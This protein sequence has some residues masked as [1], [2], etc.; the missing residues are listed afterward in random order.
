MGRVNTIQ[1]YPEA[2]GMPINQFMHQLYEQSL[3]Y[4]NIAYSENGAKMYGTTGKAL[5]DL[6]FSVASLRDSSPE[7]IL[8]K[9]VAAANEDFTLALKWIFYARDVREGLGEV[10]LFSIVMSYLINYHYW[11]VRA[12]I[13]LIPMY[14]RWDDLL[15]LLNTRA[16]SDILTIISKQ[17]HA[18][19]IAMKLKQ[20]ISLMAKWLPSINA[21]SLDSRKKALKILRYLNMTVAQYRHYL[22]RFRRYLDVVEVKMS[23]RRWDEIDYSKVPSKANLLY[24]KAFLRHDMDR[25]SQFIADVLSGKEK[26]NAGV[27]YPHEIVY[28]YISNSFDREEMDTL[29]GIW[30]NLPRVEGG[31]TIVVADGSGSMKRVPSQSSNVRCWDIATALAIYFAEQL[32]GPYN[33]QVI[34]FSEHPRYVDLRPCKN[35]FEKVNKMK[36]YTEVANTNIEAVFDLVLDTAKTNGLTQD[37][38]PKNILILSDME[39]DSC[40]EDSS[41]RYAGSNLFEAISDKYTVAGYK[42]PRVC[43]WNI[44]GS[45]GAIPMIKNDLG[46]AL[47]SGYSINN[48]KLIMSGKLDPYDALLDVLNGERYRNILP[49]PTP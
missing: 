32:N 7:F 8:E 23:E 16:E 4:E 45:S 48:V 12:I 49:D 36:L 42:M 2:G 35:L 13:P 9:F 46:V 24:S 14:G 39:F 18:D 27:V 19:T 26:M 11:K 6:N 37:Q 31:D 43:F 10:R 33:N 34:T 29:L 3:K 25:R 22:D 44:K 40:A 5:L 41:G 28:R 21:T 1:S 47:M 30:A 20:P 38:L 17:W 15:V